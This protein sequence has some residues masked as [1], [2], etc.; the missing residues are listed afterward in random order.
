MIKEVKE[1]LNTP[2]LAGGLIRTEDEVRNAL[3]AGA[4]AITTSK[5]G[6]W[7]SFT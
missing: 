2:I 3:N 1:R 6:L 7:N 4:T 5:I